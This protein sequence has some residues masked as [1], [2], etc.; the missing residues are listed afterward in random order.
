[1]SHVSKNVTVGYNGEF[2]KT[3]SISSGKGQT[4]YIFYWFL[5]PRNALLTIQKYYIFII[6][7]YFGNIMNCFIWRVGD[8]FL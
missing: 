2:Y 1:M 3:L 8:W 7:F 6:F 4:L 5:T